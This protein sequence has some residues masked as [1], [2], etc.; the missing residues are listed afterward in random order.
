MDD[1]T[2]EEGAA[3]SSNQATN[4]A[5][6][7]ERR[8]VNNSGVPKKK[9]RNIATYVVSGLIVLVMAL[10]LIFILEKQGRINT[11]LFTGIIA[12][13]KAKAP[14]AKVNG[15]VIPMSDFDSGVKQLSEVAKMQGMDS[16]SEEAIAG[17]RAEAIETLINGELLRQVA[18]EKGKVATPEA[19]DARFNEFSE[20][21][22]GR[23][24][25][26]KRMAE[27]GINEDNL[28][29]DIENG[30]LIQ[31]LFDSE[32]DKNSIEVTDEE[33]A[34]LYNEANV[35]G[36]LPPLEEV[37]EQVVEQI[38]NDKYQQK[39]ITYIEDLKSKAEIEVLI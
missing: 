11:G 16:T 18:L 27:F 24:E 4:N 5:E 29:R 10:G 36:D 15:V 14:A 2:R 38:R 25:L 33:V 32:V 3:V 37:R 13:M 39:V 8:E 22:G 21:I 17:F 20:G 28:R 30:I 9:R 26:D 12:D 31:S 6:T 35:N 19:I 23:E 34:T 1:K 7:V